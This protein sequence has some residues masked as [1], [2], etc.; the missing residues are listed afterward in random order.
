MS[1]MYSRN[2]ALG[3]SSSAQ[4]SPAFSGCR[5]GDI[6]IAST[7]RTDSRRRISGLDCAP[8]RR[9]AWRETLSGSRCRCRGR[10]SLTADRISIARFSERRIAN[11]VRERTPPSEASVGSPHRR[12]RG[13]NVDHVPWSWD[14]ASSPTS[15]PSSAHGCRQNG[16][17]GAQLS[18]RR[19]GARAPAQPPYLPRD[20]GRTPPAEGDVRDHTDCDQHDEADPSGNRSVKAAPPRGR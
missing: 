4:R 16:R 6:P 7:N 9:S 18:L 13:P 5:A 17:R 10:S 20:L 1:S 15:R 14:R 19:S 3:S 2:R 11:A 8:W 12:T